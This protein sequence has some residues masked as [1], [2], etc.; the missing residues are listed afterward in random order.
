V[1]TRGLDGGRGE[2]ISTGRITSRASA[3]QR[4]SPNIRVGVK[5]SQVQILSA[6]HAFVQL[7]SDSTA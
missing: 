5:W 1:Q 4:N 3:R 2:T 6:R 7:E